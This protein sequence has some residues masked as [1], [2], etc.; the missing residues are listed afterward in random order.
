M[1]IP[2]TTY[3]LTTQSRSTRLV[4]AVT[5]YPYGSHSPAEMHQQAD[6]YIVH[7]SLLPA[8]TQSICVQ[9]LKVHSSI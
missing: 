7:K 8:S 6:S 3:T 4:A 9:S 1:C 2:H 5:V